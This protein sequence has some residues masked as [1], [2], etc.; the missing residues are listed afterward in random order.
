M[1][2]KYGD[3]TIALLNI[4]LFDQ[5]AI[6]TEDGVDLLYL[7]TTIKITGVLDTGY[8]I[9]NKGNLVTD[10][11][12]MKSTIEDMMMRPRQELFIRFEPDFRGGAGAPFENA[13]AADA[14]FFF[15]GPVDAVPNPITTAFVTG[16]ERLL[17]ES[18]KQIGNLAGLVD[19]NQGPIPLFCNLTKFLGNDGF[20]IS[21][22]VQTWIDP[23][24]SGPTKAFP[25]ISNR[26]SMI[27]QVDMDQL[28]TVESHGVATFN[29]AYLKGEYADNWRSVIVPPI[30]KRFRRDQI[31]VEQSPDGAVLRYS[32]LDHELPVYFSTPVGENGV[33]NAT[34]IEVLKSSMVYTKPAIEDAVLAARQAYYDLKNSKQNS[35]WLTQSRLRD[36]AM[37]RQHMTQSAQEHAA[38]MKLLNTQRLVAARTARNIRP[39]GRR[40]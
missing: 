2:V 40:P 22:G 6:Y 27:H 16:N 24:L 11:V 5:R 38:K 28:C 34:R 12:T 3:I 10:P 19:G 30:Y 32:T 29:T 15:D 1:K 9:V 4:D 18:P 26:F 17:L 31:Q 33:P 20:V 35:D 7:L 36:D 25:L 13:P 21:W 14:P 39:R 8:P 37:A 23:C